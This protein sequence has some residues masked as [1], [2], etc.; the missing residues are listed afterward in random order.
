MNC[1]VIKISGHLIKDA[2]SLKSLV[3]EIEDLHRDRIRVVILPGGSIFADLIRDIQKEIG[4]DN[5]TAHWM[6]IK[7]MELYGTYIKSFSP[8]FEEAYSIEDISFILSN[9]RIPIVMPYT[10]LRKFDELPHSWSVTSD[11]IAIFIASKIGCGLVC[12]GKV[13]DGV[14]DARGGLIKRIRAEDFEKITQNVVDEYVAKL[15]ENLC[16]KVAIF[17]VKKPWILKDIVK[18]VEGEYTTVMC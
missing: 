13:V 2:N 12:L 18:G 8:L 11:S 5:D 7:A 14:K 4:F 10:I 1:I 16:I 9:N 6:A 3:K 15:V 17:N